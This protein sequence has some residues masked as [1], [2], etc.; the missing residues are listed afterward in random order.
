MS[1]QLKPTLCRKLLIVI[2]ITSFFA[3]SHNTN[4]THPVI[5]LEAIRLIQAQGQ[6]I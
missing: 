2:G 1:I 6:S 3:M 5:T 4:V